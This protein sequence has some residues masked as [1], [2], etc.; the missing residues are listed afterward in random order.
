MPPFLFARARGF[1]YNLFIMDL[2]IA[3]VIM[4]IALAATTRLKMTL[5]FFILGLAIKLNWG[6]VHP[7]SGTEWLGSWPAII[8]FG[9]AVILE[10][11]A[12]NI[13]VVEHWLDI[14]EGF[15]SP[16]AGAFI[17]ISSSGMAK[18]DPLMTLALGL[19]GAGVGAG[20]YLAHNIPKRGAR[21]V[22][23]GAFTGAS[24]LSS[25]SETGLAAAE[26]IIAV[27]W[28]WI[29]LGLAC[30]SLL[31]GWLLFIFLRKRPGVVS[32]LVGLASLCALGLTVLP[33]FGIIAWFTLAWSFI[34]LVIAGRARSW[35][36]AVLN[37]V[38]LLLSLV[39]LIVGLGIF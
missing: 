32:V 1:I 7:A 26:S 22:S 20:A 2:Y 23:G 39:R 29:A 14:A 8:C 31:G 10:I 6:M 16:V 3:S 24:F 9:V 35:A 12:D 19:M 15:I 5:P 27:H 33:F 25:I 37:F 38:A 34:G 11:I 36:G 28:P 18:F 30:L 21:D 13:P 4:G 17:V